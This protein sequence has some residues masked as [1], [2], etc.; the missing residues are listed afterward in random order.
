MKILI[1]AVVIAS[2]LAVPALVFAKE[3]QLLTREQVRNEFIELKQARYE[4]TDYNYEE[5]LR[6]AEAKIARQHDVQERGES[7]RSHITAQ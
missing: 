1:Q 2:A 5:S 6:A 7:E 4:P 3:T